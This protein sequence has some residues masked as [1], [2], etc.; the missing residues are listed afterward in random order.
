MTAALILPELPPE[1]QTL[2]I[3]ESMRPEDKAFLI[4]ELGKLSTDYARLNVRDEEHRKAL[5]ERFKRFEDRLAKLECGADE[6]SRHELIRVERELAR[7]VTVEDKWKA[8][9]WGLVAVL[10]TSAIVGLVTHWLS[11]RG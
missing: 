6:S 7:R 3:P 11:T 1:S 5:E 10:L 2:E 8:R 9:I 4:R